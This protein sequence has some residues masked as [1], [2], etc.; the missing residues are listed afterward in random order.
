MPAV[1]WRKSDVSCGKTIIKKKNKTPQILNR[2]DSLLRRLFVYLNKAGIAGDLGDDAAVINGGRRVAVSVDSYSE[3]VHFNDL[4]SDDS[5]GYRTVTGAVSDIA[6]MGSAAESVLISVGLP[7]TVSDKKFFALYGGIKKACHRWHLKVEGGDIAASRNLYISV[8]ATGPAGKNIRRSG[9][10]AGDVLFITSYPGLSSAGLALLKSGKRKTN[11]LVKKFLYP[12]IFSGDG[13]KLFP[14]VSALM[15]SSD[16]LI[17]SCRS[18]SRLSGVS[19]NIESAL[20]P[21]KKELMRF[22]GSRK[23]AL[24]TALEGGE[25]YYL[26]GSSSPGKFA[27]IRTPVYRIGTAG[28]G[29]GVF[30]DGNRTDYKGFRHFVSR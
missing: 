11:F 14:F 12:D 6:A 17:E 20:V 16:G 13:E 25:D 9:A 28:A 15:D 5:I 30:L 3:G 22:C 29:K 2:E 23:K 7:R 26:V 19:V 24:K 21:L 27:K 8:T 18:I 1:F 10:K 4:V